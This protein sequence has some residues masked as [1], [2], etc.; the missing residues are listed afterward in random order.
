[1]SLRIKA[2]LTDIVSADVDLVVT[3]ARIPGLASEQLPVARS[4]D[5]IVF[6][7]P[8]DWR[9]RY[10]VRADAGHW[11]QSGAHDY[12][13]ARWYRT[14][15]G[16]ADQLTLRRVGFATGADDPGVW[17]LDDWVR[18]ALTTLRGTPTSVTDVVFCCPSPGG[19][20]AFAAG[21][22]RTN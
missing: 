4:E 12:L 5:G 6:E 3:S 7:S 9:P 10:V 13:R 18:L 19:V 21:I 16:F 2:T 8:I 11:Q 1:V 20:E 17:P 14:G 15:L 22:V